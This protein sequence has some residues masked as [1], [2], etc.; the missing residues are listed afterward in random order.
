[1][2]NRLV[3]LSLRYKF[4]V[5]IVFAVVA[6]LGISA[7]R[8][9]PIDA[10]PD[11]TPVQ[12][13]VYTE[14]P[15]L[16]A[17]DVEQL[18]TTPVESALAGLPKVQEIRSVSLFGLSY[19]SVYFKDDMDIYFA[20]QLVNERLQE[21]GDRLPEGYGKPSMGPNTSG[22]GQVYWYTVERAPGVSKEQ[23]T[24]MDLRTWQEWTVRLILRTA[25]GVDDV[26]SWGGGERQFQVQIDPQR[27]YARHLGFSD[28]INAIPAN[29]GQVGGNVM[30][31]GRE[32]FLVRGLGL[33]KSVE[34]IGA[35]VL[36]SE[37]GV[38]VYLR[39]VARVTEAPAP[40]F[41]AV[42]RDGQEVVMGQ[43]LARIG[44]NAKNVVEAVKG[45]LEVVRAALPK[46][47][48]LR[49]IYERTDLVN[50][51]VETAVR[52]LIEG[53]ILVAIILFL[54]L[55]E[56]R[57]ALVVIVTL[58]LAM[59]IAFIG[60]GQAGLSA[61]LMSL[62]GLAIGIG[63]MVDGAVVMVENAFRIMAERLEHGEKVDR[64]SAVLAAA[65]EV[66]NPI[67]FAIIIIIVVFLPLFALE[68]LE[69]KM[70]KPM[71]FNIAFAMAGSLILSLTLIP[72]LASMILKPKEERDTWLVA[73][74][75]CIY[76]PLLDKALAKKRT[77]VISAVAALIVS[78]ALFPFLGKEFMPQLQEG[79]IMWRVTG[80][81]STSL[82]ESIRTS[83]TIAAAFK[84]FPEVETTL[85][86]IGRAEKGDTAD[87]N[88]MEIYTALKP[89]DEWT[90][91]RNIKELEAAMQE[92]L[93][94]V[95]PNVVP[96]YTQ[97]IQMRVEELISGVRATL[98][99]KLYGEDLRELDK[100]SGRL[101]STLATVPGVADLALEANLGKPQ[102]RI[103]VNRDELALYGL[104]AEDVLTIVRNGLGGEPVS[105]LLDGVKRFDIAVRLDDSARVS[106]ESVRHIPLRTASG[107]LVP[108][109]RVAEISIAEGYSF[110]R[111]EQLQRYAVIQMDVRGRDVDG[112]VKDANAAIKQ[113]VHLPPGYW[114]EWGGA[115]ENQQ[116]ALAKLALIV[117][118]TIFFIF[119]LL[120]TAFN[121]VKYATLI[122]ANVP[123]ATI[124]GLIALAVTGQYLSVPSAIGFIAVFGVAMLNGIVLVSFL[125][126]LRDKGLSVREAVVQGTALRLRPVLMTASV[127][128][129]GL[130]PMLL[131]TGVGAETQRPLAT[132]VVG[133]LISSTLLTL[134]L[135][136]VLYEWLETRAERK[137]AGSN[138]QET[139]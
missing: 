137:A 58:P 120:Y 3:E 47:M 5:L 127:A 93:E 113:Q 42:T 112:F 55:G 24:D 129:L 17:E 130:V 109:S 56:V 37:D 82:N 12:V 110:V 9:V 65:K 33:L 75:K 40:R 57:S 71:A 70:F 114:I 81:P 102:I 89:E 92:T 68:G 14:S 63:M 21:I 105:V 60:M 74:I 104:N 34:D 79:S 72:V 138:P 13:N 119:V 28:V 7:V 98:A 51:A 77:V 132:V 18:L 23:V 139:V 11:V 115:F 80:I 107:A 36:K 96:S 29:N 49:P 35:I 2:L 4:L 54:F 133:G 90:T 126:E 62:A 83:N 66:A 103:Q 73:R 106:V 121:S 46:T 118:V 91:G 1:M 59:L 39:D 122:I 76:R 44:E 111:R 69:G 94:K 8:N 52:A 123:F 48:V 43:A 10:F 20:R 27:L 50:K 100:L 134:V 85:S 78:L 53:S 124:G 6:F 125:N 31:V 26:S 19:V 128:I 95:V 136:P 64:T 131:S 22:L 97:P 61:N 86:M 87:V 99:L 41:G 101:K 135:L 16:A 108:L 45:K 25:P 38:P 15:G 88:Y 116:R 67:A 30:D 117:P 32:Q 84:Q